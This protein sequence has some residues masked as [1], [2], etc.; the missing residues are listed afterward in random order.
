MIPFLLVPAFVASVFVY[1]A[2]INLGGGVHRTQ[3]N[4]E[5]YARDYARTFH[6]WQNPV[7]QCFGLDTD[8]NGY[9]TCSVARE[10]GAPIRQIECAANIVLQFNRGCRQPQLR[11]LEVQ[12][13]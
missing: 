7:V 11:T 5:K 2:Y 10:P 8:H 4:A 6:N 13:Q 1:I 9:V 3:A 12:A